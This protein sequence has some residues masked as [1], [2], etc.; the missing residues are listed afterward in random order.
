MDVISPRRDRK[1][2]PLAPH[3]TSEERAALR[4]YVVERGGMLFYDDCGMNGLLAATVANEL[5]RTFPEYPLQNL[6]HTHK[7]YTIY[8]DLPRPP[9]VVMC[10]G[11]L[12][13]IR[14][15]RSSNTKKVLLITIGS[16]CL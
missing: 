7:I 12:K 10:S 8:Y 1:E 3:F 9:T 13:T 6:M 5:Y 11:N 4:K 16:G 2:A 15:R 14:N